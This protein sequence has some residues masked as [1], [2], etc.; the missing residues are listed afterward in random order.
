MNWPVKS[1]GVTLDFSA[2][3]RISSLLAL[4]AF[5]FAGPVIAA[6]RS[7]HDSDA[8]YLH[9]I[10]LYDIDNRKIDA[11]STRPYSSANTCGRCHEYEE[12]SHGWHFNAFRPGTADGRGG[13]PWI[14]TDP[15]TG[16]QLPLSY[17]DW[18]HTYNP[19][20]IGVSTFEMTKQF[21]GRIPGGNMGTGEPADPDET[22]NTDSDSSKEEGEQDEPISR[23]EFSGALEVDCMICHAVSGAYDFNSRREQIEQENFAWGPTAGLRLGAIK[24]NVSKIKDG[25]DPKDEAIQEKMPKVTYD[26]SR[27][28]FDGK[29][30]MDLVRKPSS[31]ACYQCHSNRTVGENGIDARWIHDDDVHLRAGMDC[32]DCHRNGINHHIARGYDGEQN[33]SGA[34]TMETLSCVGCHMGVDH[35]NDVPVNSKV[36]ARPGRLGSPHPAHAGLPPLH[37]DKLSCTACH[38]GPVPRD[39]AVRIMTSLAHGIGEEG[40]RTG[41]EFPAILGP[42]YSKDSSGKVFPNRVMWAAFWGT[43]VDGKITP[44]PPEQVYDLTRKSLRVRKDFVSELL[45]PKMSSSDLKKILGEDRYKTKPDQWTSEETEK[46]TTAQTEE[47]TA[48]FG[49]KVYAALAAIEKELEVE[50]AVYVS[51]GMVYAKGDEEDTVKVIDVT[52]DQAT[53]MVQ[54]PMAHN[55]RPAGWSLGV[56]GC[57]ECHSED[58]KLFTSRVAAIGPGP[59]DGPP[60]SMASLQSVNPDQRL[61]WNE[62]FKGRASFKYVIAS[63]IGI[64]LM[65]LC[66]GI[67]AVASRFAGRAA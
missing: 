23:F 21:G 17:R 10:D 2:L 12:I 36:T 11:D 19:Q 56:A 58:A 47:G 46:V 28:G 39:Q 55:V 8:R 32:T 50:S 48:V 40:H 34:T 57:T 4:I 22:K 51:S 49:E 16:T 54:W 64:L 13:E 43:M 29:V 37:F 65:I 67:G 60:I 14:W 5:L 3:L 18:S 52:D 30:F 41:M 62:L 24:G 35:G 33:P 27:F 45:K 20:K 26:P 31:N 66:V 9:H 44:I 7:H 25:S 53:R 1:D 42:V 59:D 6:D 63:S 38:G 61:A 15:R